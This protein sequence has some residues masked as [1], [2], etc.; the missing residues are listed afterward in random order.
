MS[1]NDG[2]SDVVLSGKIHITW[3][4]DRCGHTN[5]EDIE[6]DQNGVWVYC[7]NPNCIENQSYIIVDISTSGTYKGICDLPLRKDS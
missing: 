1:W 3:V 7:K 4:C 2:N 5:E 6:I